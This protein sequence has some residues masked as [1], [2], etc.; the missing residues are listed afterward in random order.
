MAVFDHTEFSMKFPTKRVTPVNVLNHDKT[1]HIIAYPGFQLIA[2]NQESQPELGSIFLA[3]VENP[4]P[5]CDIPG[6]NPDYLV[7]VN[8]FIQR[9]GFLG[10][11]LPVQSNITVYQ[12]R[13]GQYDIEFV[14]NCM[15]RCQSHDYHCN[16]FIV[17]DVQSFRLIDCVSRTVITAPPNSKHAALSYVWGPPVANG[18][19]ASGNL[20]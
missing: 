17:Q 4:R 15:I 13:L 20:H 8:T 3:V 19:I 11:V 7:R 9:T 6:V 12:T 14:R 2:K 18:P 10:L 16:N 1:C 5:L